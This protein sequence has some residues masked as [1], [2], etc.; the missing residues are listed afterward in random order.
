MAKSI[1]LADEQYEQ[2]AAS[3]VACG[4]VVGRGPKSELA[5]FVVYSAKWASNN[6][7]Q[8]TFAICAPE[9][10]AE[11]DEQGDRFC[12]VCGQPLSR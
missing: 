12:R 9:Y 8:R 10:H 3:A 6:S 7:V 11:L 4:F 5:K 1:Y 2:V